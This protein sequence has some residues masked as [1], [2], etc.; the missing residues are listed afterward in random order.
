MGEEGTELLIRIILDVLEYNI[1]S[2]D[3]RREFE[4]IPE[5]D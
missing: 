1:I 4:N 2:E 5:Q 3:W